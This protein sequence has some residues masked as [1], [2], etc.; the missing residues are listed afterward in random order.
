MNIEIN[1]CHIDHERVIVKVQAFE[2]GDSLGSSLG[3]GKTIDLAEQ[4]AIE[5]LNIRISIPDIKAKNQQKI[6]LD[7]KNQV[8][9][10]PSKSLN[11]VDKQ[12]IS[13]ENETN[14]IENNKLNKDIHIP[15]DW[16]KDLATIDIELKRLNWNKQDEQAYLQHLLGYNNRNK[17]TKYNEL[18]ILVEGLK[19]LKSG[20]KPD[21]GKESIDDLIIKSSIIINKLNWD[22]RQGREFLQSKFKVKSRQ[23]LDKKQ[24]LQFIILLK[25]Q[26]TV[27]SITTKSNL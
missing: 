13:E 2:G 26:L 25:Q 19:F 11:V 12:A 9:E 21:F 24:L 5:K 1:L 14:L 16:G 4:R 3:E 20:S 17:I 22:S 10:Q 8:L 27:N 23:E 6:L 7:N 15:N 18:Q